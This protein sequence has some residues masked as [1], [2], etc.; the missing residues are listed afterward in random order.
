MKQRLHFLKRLS[1]LFVF[2]GLMALP[3]VGWGQIAAW[4][5][6][7]Q[8]SPATFAAT[9]FNSNL[10]STSDANNITRG[11]GAAASTASNSFRTTGF[12]N[13]GISTAN[14]DYFQV[15]LT[16][17]TGYSL[18]LSS[19]D[20][21]FA[22]T[23]GFYASPG[24]TSQFAY[25]L[26]GS[27]FILIGSPVQSTSL[28]ITETSLTG[29]PALQNVAAGTT[30]TLRY[31]ASGQ[32][33]TGGWGF[34]SPSSGVN[35]LAIGGT[36]DIAPTIATPNP[37]TLSGFSTVTGTESSAQTF[38][39]SGTNLTADLVVTAPTSYEVREDGIGSFGLS[40]SYTPSSGTV[41]S[42]TIEVRIAASAGVGTPAGNVICSST[43]ATPQN[44][45][46]SGTVKAPLP[47][48]HVTL[49]EA[50]ASNSSSITVTW[51]DNDG[52]Q[53]AAGFL[54][55]ANKTGIFTD[56]V[57]GTP[58]TDDEALADGTGVKNILPDVQT[59]TWINLNASTQYFFKIFP[60]TN[61]GVNITFKTD[62]TV[63]TV[64]ATTDEVQ[65]IINFDTD[66]NWTAGSA[67]LSSYASNH[68][69]I[70]NNWTFTG[71][72]A[73]RNGT[74]A[75]DG[76]AG[77]LGTYSWRLR[78][79]AVTWTATYTAAL[80]ANQNFTGFG[81]DA[82]R[83]DGIPTPAYTVSYSV[84]GGTN[85]ITASSIGSSGVLDNAAFGN[86]SAW[87]TFSQLISSPSG[88]AANQLVV[89]LAATTGERIMVDN[90]TYQISNEPTVSTFTGTGNWSAADRWS[91]SLPGA[92]TNVIID[93]AATINTD[94]EVANLTI[95]AT[96]S[97]TIATEGKLKVTGTLTNSASL[98][99]L[100]VE[101]GGSLIH[102]TA[103]V[104]A[105]VR[106]T[107]AEAE[108]WRLIGS[109]VENQPVSG[110]WTPAGNYPGGVG[111]DFYAYDEESATWL[112]Q[113]LGVNNI[114]SFMQGKGYLVS[115][116]AAAQ[117]KEYEG[118]LNNG[119][120]PVSLTKD[121]VGAYS[122]AN[123]I[124]NPYA[125]GI[126]WNMAD[127]GLLADDFAYVYDASALSGSGAYIEIDGGLTEAYV[128]PNQGFFVVADEGG[129]FTF[130][131][132]MR[133]HGGSFYKNTKGVDH[134]KLKLSNDSFYDETTVRKEENSMNTRD[135][136]D[137]L[138]FY[139]YNPLSPQIF[140]L[141]SDAVKVSINSLPE[142]SD[143]TIIQ[144][145]TLLPSEGAYQISLVE[146]EG[147]F[148]DKII[149]LEDQLTGVNYNLSENGSYYFIAS[150]TN[151][152]NRFLLHFGLVSVGE[153]LPT[154]TLQAYAYNN[155]L[156][157]NSS[158]EKA[159]LSVY[160][161]QGRLLLQRE[162]NESGLQSVEM[163]MPAG[164]YIVRMQNT[165]QSKSVKIVVQ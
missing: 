160:D 34:N 70:E 10:V 158:L 74:T 20:A 108:H 81:F 31:Y 12:Q 36:V 109:P 27:D 24:V 93:G 64:N 42:K 121:N 161:V 46:V 79:A 14:T 96:R 124:A 120:V 35:G 1:V 5:F 48:N 30:V 157:V 105:T 13:N 22:G 118:E 147:V 128:A 104:S 11:A 62:G 66:V 18:S 56:P 148:A 143:E 89:R 37:T 163:K 86:S 129:T 67:A 4:D 59:Y 61:S 71:G 16:A 113:K 80:N 92:T 7:G 145:G 72:D 119:N 39:I 58:Q 122:G 52:A 137:A 110:G 41:A 152:P 94:I 19:I 23:A 127:R 149:Y 25:S 100:V 116:E 55:L 98:T 159:S 102:N 78:D 112:N 49:F 150:G 82:R 140:S 164:V 155:R 165:Q 103:D 106:R 126:D 90:F 130:N 44:V 136:R 125:S 97:L 63:P 33:T 115:F 68:T 111:Y 123:L 141:T 139:S 32:T 3:G 135:R 69:Y 38:T 131:N 47:S 43:G 8:S 142:I 51:A 88:L 133:K 77:A 2:F 138:K 101:S 151:D 53:A 65:I 6:F 153:Q 83:W 84:D 17:T 85:W 57:N 60:Y 15:T 29:I 107:F 40:V 95:N 76:F 99:G 114:T 21:R 26:N 50:T 154:E 132:T 28:T 156:F 73:L 144:L 91:P 117:T 9:T 45:A 87:S 162:I 146:S 134:L 75:Q 54:I